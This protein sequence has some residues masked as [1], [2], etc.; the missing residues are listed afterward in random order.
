M[1]TVQHSD[2][3]IGVLFPKSA[4]DRGTQA[5]TGRLAVANVAAFSHHTRGLAGCRRQSSDT[6]LAGG[7]G[8][9]H[10]KPQE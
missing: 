7:H 5:D 8:V 2:A 4:K 3:A 9:M 10:H 6:R 1:E